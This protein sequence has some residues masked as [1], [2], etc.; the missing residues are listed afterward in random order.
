MKR[1][2]EVRYHPLVYQDIQNVVEFYRKETKS[3]RLG[4]RFI[5]AVITTLKSLDRSAL[6]YQVRYDDIRLI[7][8][9]PFPFMT[10][11][12][13][14]VENGV[15]RVEAIFHMSENPEGWKTRTR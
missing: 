10:H 9:L 12:R 6:H 11:Y 4:N 3:D 1:A 7:P 8:I 13:V 15:V 2:F 5:K 14:D